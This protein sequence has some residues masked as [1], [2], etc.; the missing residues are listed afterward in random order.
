MRTIKQKKLS[1]NLIPFP[2]KETFFKKVIYF[3]TKKSLYEYYNK[4]KNKE[5][6][7]FFFLKLNLRF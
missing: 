1:Y 7:N 6:T 5:L 3:K 2:L 4:I